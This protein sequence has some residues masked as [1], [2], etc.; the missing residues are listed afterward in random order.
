MKPSFSSLSAGKSGRKQFFAIAALVV[1]G[2]VIGAL[3]LSYGSSGPAS[4]EHSEHAEEAEGKGG[5]SHGHSEE[6]GEHESEAQAKG[7]NGGQRFVDGDFALELLLAEEGGEP[8][9]KAWLYTKNTIT[10]PSGSSV[11]I[12]LT[13][14]SGERQE[15]K[16]IPRGDLLEGEQVVAEPHVFEA[17]VTGRTPKQSFKFAFSREE[18]KVE[19]SDAQIQSSG[20]AV[21]TSAAAR[22]RTAQQFPGEIRFNEDRTAHIVP[23]VSGVVDGVS[24]N[25]GQQVQQGQVLAVISSTAVSE[26]RAELQAAQKRRELAKTTYEREKSLWEEKISPQQDVL[27]AQQTLREAEIAVANATQKLLA[28][29][30]APESSA[31]GRFELRAPFDGV[32]VEK[33]IAQGEAVREDSNVFTI[34][35]LS[36]VWAEMSISARD[37]PQVRVG[38]KVV[39]RS[40]AFDATAKGS[41]SYVGVLIGEQTRTARA[42]V[43]LANPQG[44]WRPGLYVNVEVVAEEKMAPVTVS[45][46][47]IQTIDEKPVVFVKT[48]GG[49]IPQ[50]VQLGRSDE[51]RVEIVSGLRAGVP[52]AATGSF[53][54]KSEQG[55]G[56]ATHAH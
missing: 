47:A 56:S 5:D 3:I 52:Y 7:P 54:V 21:E 38:E 37:L 28:L 17:A 30:A 19:M 45:S 24:A 44:A 27:Q 32:V 25:L 42:R 39:V 50:P 1:A 34:S 31:L 22:I 26:V 43:T 46:S 36:T 15:I 2:I 53:I 9:F 48:R 20:I 16:L 55:K 10:T 13:R 14:P 40:G 4:E 11:S 6:E 41:V 8:R 18:G 29:G 23:R 33:H 49:F 35:D 12:S 51:R